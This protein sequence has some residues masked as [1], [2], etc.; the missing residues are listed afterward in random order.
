MMRSRSSNFARAVAAAYAMRK[1]FDTGTLRFDVFVPISVLPNLSVCQYTTFCNLHGLTL[2]EF[3]SIV[4]SQDGF[5]L[6]RGREHLIV[7]NNDP[8]I[9]ETRR[10]FTIA[11]ELG[12]Y[13]LNHHLQ[14]ETE[15]READC[16]ARNLLA[17]RLV[18]IKNGINYEDYPRVFG[19]SSTAARMCEVREVTDRQYAM[20]I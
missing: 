7:Y 14:T 9:P 2:D 13:V 11:H 6:R 4:P 18:A 16:F 10:R 5:S 19:I 1:Q 17:P 8:D 3:L 12:H 15:E 20:S